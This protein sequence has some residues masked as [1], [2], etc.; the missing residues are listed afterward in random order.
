MNKIDIGYGVEI[1]KRYIDGEFEGFAYWHICN[2][3]RVEDW[4]PVQGLKSWTL[5]NYE[6]LTIQPSLLCPVCKHHGYIID[7]KWVPV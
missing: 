5:I 2:G 7:G 4:I 3:N 1:E 6:P